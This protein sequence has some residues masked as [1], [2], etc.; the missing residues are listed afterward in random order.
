MLGVNDV[1]KFQGGTI[2]TCQVTSYQLGRLQDPLFEIQSHKQQE[3]AW[4]ITLK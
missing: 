3:I 2:F 1:T 4:H